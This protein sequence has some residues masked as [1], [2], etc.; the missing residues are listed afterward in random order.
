M[1]TVYA[2]NGRRDNRR[3]NNFAL[4]SNMKLMR[5]CVLFMSME[6]RHSTQKHAHIAHKLCELLTSCMLDC[7]LGARGAGWG[8]LDS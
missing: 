7:Q 4:P 3:A 6:L 5:L 8:N 1:L 2:E